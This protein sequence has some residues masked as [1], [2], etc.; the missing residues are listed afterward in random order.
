MPVW[1]SGQLISLKISNV[2][3]MLECSASRT[4]RSDQHSRANRVENGAS[5]AAVMIIIEALDC[6]SQLKAPAMD[7]TTE[8]PIKVSTATRLVSVLLDPDP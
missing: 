2:E 3:G 8:L 5:R 1:Q 7:L 6:R 4:A